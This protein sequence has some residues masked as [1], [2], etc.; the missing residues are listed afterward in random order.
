ME[1]RFQNSDNSQ[2]TWQYFQ[3]SWRFHF[4]CERLSPKSFPWCLQRLRAPLRTCELGIK[5]SLDVTRC[6]THFYSAADGTSTSQAVI[7]S[8]RLNLAVLKMYMRAP[9]LLNHLVR[10]SLISSPLPQTPQQ[11]TFNNTEWSDRVEFNA[12]SGRPSNTQSSRATTTSRPA[13]SLGSQPQNIKWVVD[14]GVIRMKHNV[15]VASVETNG[16]M[17]FDHYLQMHI[18]PLI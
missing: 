11:L 9:T 16:L 5:K 7:I 17:Q 6:G 14:S 13:N 18:F 10:L 15:C 4:K 2:T 12:A 8:L 3:A 1:R